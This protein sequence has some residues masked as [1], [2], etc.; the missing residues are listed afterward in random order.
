MR[1]EHT[2][3]RANAAVRVELSERGGEG[4]SREVGVVVVVKAH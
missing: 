4:G 1:R 2:S 3:E